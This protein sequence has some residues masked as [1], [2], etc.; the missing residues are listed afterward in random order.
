MSKS[1]P[2]IRAQLNRHISQIEEDPYSG[3][4]LHGEFDKCWAIDSGEFRIIYKIDESAKHLAFLVV[5]PRG[6][7]YK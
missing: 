4:P 3:Y 2:K 1:T 7:A 5:R 6:D